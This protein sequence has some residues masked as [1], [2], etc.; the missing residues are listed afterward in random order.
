L[1]FWAIGGLGSFTTFSA[2]SAEVVR[3]LTA[4][5]VVIA[6]WYVI[7]STAGGLA[8]TVLGQRLGLVRR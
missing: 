5:A 2:F 8:A 7:A 1:Q 4:N 6:A 3:L